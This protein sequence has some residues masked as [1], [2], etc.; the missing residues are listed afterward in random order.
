MIVGEGSFRK[1]LEELSDK[2]N[3]KSNIHFF[4]HKPFNEMLEILAGSDVAIVPHLRTDNNDA[5]AQ[6]SF[7][8]TCISINR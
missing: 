4:G 7:I 5:L 2:L 6:T 8:N 1:G 3:I